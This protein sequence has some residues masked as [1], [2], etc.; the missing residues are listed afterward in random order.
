MFL[1]IPNGKLHPGDGVYKNQGKNQGRPG[2]FSREKV[3]EFFLGGTSWERWR[4]FCWLFLFF[5][6][7]RWV[8]RGEKKEFS[9]FAESETFLGKGNFLRKRF[10]FLFLAL[11]NSEKHD[12]VFVDTFFV[13]KMLGKTQNDE[14]GHKWSTLW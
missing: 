9:A 12:R 11:A 13:V 5:E 3:V 14:T 1:D 10:E 8:E 2:G 6:G 7:R 4:S